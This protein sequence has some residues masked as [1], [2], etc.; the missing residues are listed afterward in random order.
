MKHYIVKVSRVVSW[1]SLPRDG[2]RYEMA[3]ACPKCGT[4]AVRVDPIYAAPTA[5]KDGVFAT[6]K[7]QVIVS[8]E[9]Y[10]QLVSVGAEGMRQVTNMKKEPIDFWSLEPQSILPPW[11]QESGGYTT[12]SQCAY[13]KRDGFFDVTKQASALVY[14]NI[15]ERDFLATWEHYGISRLRTPFTESIFA[16]PRLIISERVQKVLGAYRGVAFDAVTQK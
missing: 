7:L 4:G 8:K 11:N 15:P 16:V 9:V 13:C 12:D 1:V 14:Q 3:S 2:G 6:H 5:C 10:Q